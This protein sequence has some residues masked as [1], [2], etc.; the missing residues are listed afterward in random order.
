M[1]MKRL[2]LAV[3]AVAEVVLLIWVVKLQR[4]SPTFLG[5][6]WLTIQAMHSYPIH[7][8]VRLTDRVDS[9][10]RKYFASQGMSRDDAATIERYVVVTDRDGSSKL[11][12]DVRQ[13]SILLH[14]VDRSFFEPVRT[15]HEAAA[16]QSA[17]K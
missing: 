12:L 4:V 15:G 1:N 7:G 3:A 2:G 16:Q 6:P 17:Q 9:T 13:G 14:A 5:H 11:N 10:M 8:R